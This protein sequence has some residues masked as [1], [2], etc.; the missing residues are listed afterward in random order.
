MKKYI[1]IYLSVLLFLSLNPWLRPDPAGVADDSS[2]TWDF[3]DH[4]LAYAGLTIMLLASCPSHR[5]HPLNTLAV[6]AAV[7]VLGFS[8]EIA[9]FLF[10]TRRQF[11]LLDAEANASGA[12]VGTL[13]YVSVISFYNSWKNG[14]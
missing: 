1:L 12:L 4:C 6:L 5:K 3:I 2:L 14:I 9:Q 7:I 13:L 8:I 11:S 10:T